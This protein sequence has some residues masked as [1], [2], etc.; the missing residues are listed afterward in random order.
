MQNRRQGAEREEIARWAILARSQTA[1]GAE[2][3]EI[4]RW[5]ILARSQTAGVAKIKVK[6]A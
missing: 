3:E 6:K 4:A 2:R 5:A 1:G